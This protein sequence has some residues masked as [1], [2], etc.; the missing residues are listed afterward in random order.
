MPLESRAWREG[1]KSVCWGE[2]ISVI[3]E[4]RQVGVAISQ[5]GWVQAVRG[6]RLFGVTR[7]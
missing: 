2:V 7:G 4:C 3:T 1:V 6:C 5:V